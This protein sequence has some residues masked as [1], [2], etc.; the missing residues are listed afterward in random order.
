MDGGVGAPRGGSIDG[1][2]VLGRMTRTHSTRILG[3][4]RQR[5]THCT[6]RPVESSAR[7]RCFFNSGV[8]REVA[9][10]RDVPPVETVDLVYG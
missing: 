2:V 6:T 9:M 1:L 7:S 4:N 10:S 5:R 8:L 3:P